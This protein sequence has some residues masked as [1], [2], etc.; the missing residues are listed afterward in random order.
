MYVLKVDNKEM[1]EKRMVE[2]RKL[3]IYIIINTVVKKKICS[4]FFK[5]MP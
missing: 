3:Y 1:V 2:K 5:T 4:K